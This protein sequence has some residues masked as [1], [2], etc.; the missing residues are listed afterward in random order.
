MHRLSNCSRRI[1][2][3]KTPEANTYFDN[4]FE[5]I[6]GVPPGNIYNYDE[7]NVV[8][9]PGV[10]KC[11]VRQGLGRVERKISHSKQAVSVMF[12][13]NAAGHFLPPMAI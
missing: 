7:T 12:C 1:V 10:K 11:I 4:L 8:D 2:N 13:V 9:D 3:T 6:D 5:V